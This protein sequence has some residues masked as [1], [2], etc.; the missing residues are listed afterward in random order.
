MTTEFKSHAPDIKPHI[1]PHKTLILVGDGQK[2]LFLRNKAA[3]S[4]SILWSNR[5]WNAII[6]QRASRERIVQGEPLQ[7]SELLAAVSRLRIEAGA[8]VAAYECRR[9][10]SIRHLAGVEE[11]AEHSDV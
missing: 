10:L 2:A 8:A 9:E 3:P 11:F 1:I 7:A 6:R 5:F 4:T